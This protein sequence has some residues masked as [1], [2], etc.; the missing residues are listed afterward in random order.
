MRRKTGVILALVLV[1]AFVFTACA[2]RRPLQTPVQ[3]G[4]GTTGYNYNRGTGTTT[5]NRTNTGTY[6]GMGPS[7]NNPYDLGYGTG[8]NPGAGNNPGYGGY[9]ATGAGTNYGGTGTTGN[10]GGVA[11][12]GNYGTLPGKDNYGGGAT[13]IGTPSYYGGYGGYGGYNQ[14]MYGGYGNDYRN[15][16]GSNNS[17][18]YG[19]NNTGGTT[20]ADGIARSIEQ[21]AGVDNATVVVNG[22][23]AYVGIDTDGDLTGRNI[24]YGNAT[25]LD[26]VKRSCAQRVKSTDPRIQTVYVSTDADFFERLR[27]VGDRVKSGSPISGFRNELTT[28][29]RGLNPV[30][31]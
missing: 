22:N 10:Y 25:G 28:L 20:Q 2:V 16:G 12:K 8:N 1:F 3:P 18:N 4:Q 19:L 31:Q 23:T 11:S 26:A 24:S 17:P 7:S 13:G 27:S 21:M 30:R 29:I 15:V 14:G 9:G 6:N 5:G